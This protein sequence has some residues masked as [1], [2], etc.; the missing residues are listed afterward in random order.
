MSFLVDTNLLLR[1]ID[2]N[3]AMNRTA[4]EALT[5]LRQKGEPLHIIPQNLVEFWNVYTRPLERNGL[6]RT[7]TEASVEVQQ[8]RSL[9]TLLPDTAAIYPEWERLVGRYDVRGVNVHDARLVSAMLVHELSHI[10]TFN[11]RD[12]R[13]YSEIVAVEPT[14]L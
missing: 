1:S 7:P 5:W 9:F 11:T 8:L 12:F 6:G 14:S 13:R 3:H 4:V 2:L 10:L